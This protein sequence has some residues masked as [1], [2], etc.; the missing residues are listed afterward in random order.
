MATA[1]D[2]GIELPLTPASFNTVCLLVNAFQ[3]RGV[4][5]VVADGVEKRI[6]TD[7]CH[8]EAMALDRVLKRFKGMV[9]FVHSK[10]IDAYFVSCAGV[11]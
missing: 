7:R 9:E 6:H 10:I 4:A 2:F 8:I 5:G 11:S 3:E 1:A